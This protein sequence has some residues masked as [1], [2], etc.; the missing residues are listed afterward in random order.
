MVTESVKILDNKMKIEN[1][2]TI[3][4]KQA[5]TK[6]VSKQICSNPK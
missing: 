3:K 5:G 4:E 1:Q 6:Y 2:K